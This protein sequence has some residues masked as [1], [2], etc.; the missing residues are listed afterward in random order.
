[1]S[2]D[3]EKVLK[4]KLHEDAF[5]FIT[6]SEKEFADWI[7]RVRWQAK[8]C[9][10][11][12]WELKRIKEKQEQGLLIELDSKDELIEVLA[13]LVLNS[14]FGRCYMCTNG[15]KNITLDGENNGCDGNCKQEEFTVDDLL[16]KIVAELKRNKARSEAEEA[17]AK[18]KGE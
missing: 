10:E 1:M 11:L 18:M 16:K 15:M 5:A 9:D 4:E 14:E 6:S 2:I 7:E 13:K 3:F 17:L 8:R 12:A